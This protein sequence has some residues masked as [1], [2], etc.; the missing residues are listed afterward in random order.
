MWLLPNSFFRVLYFNFKQESF[1]LFPLNDETKQ[2]HTCKQ[3][4]EVHCFLGFVIYFQDDFGM[5]GLR[6]KAPFVT[7]VEEIVVRPTTDV[8]DP[9]ESITKDGIKNTFNDVQVIR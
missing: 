3:T 1:Y 2:K 9:I 7:V 6:M 5:P 8:L 4:L